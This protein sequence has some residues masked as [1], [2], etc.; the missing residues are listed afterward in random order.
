[1]P[2][3]CFEQSALFSG[4]SNLYVSTSPTQKGNGVV[5][6]DGSSTGIV[7]R[8]ICRIDL[9]KEGNARWPH[10]HQYLADSRPTRGKHG[11]IRARPFN[12]RVPTKRTHPLATMRAGCEALKAFSK[13]GDGTCN[14]VGGERFDPLTQMDSSV[15]ARGCLREPNPVSRSV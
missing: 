5:R 1:M 13:V 10:C 7:R 15:C 12:A 14:G 4:F 9:A 3:G 8:P 2:E 6:L 11:R